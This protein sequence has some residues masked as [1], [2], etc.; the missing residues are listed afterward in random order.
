MTCTV[1]NHYFCWVCGL[2][3]RH[4]VH[5]FENFNL[6]SCKRFPRSKVGLA[7]RVFYFFL[8]F[9][10]L[11]LLLAIIP[12]FLGTALGGYL[13]IAFCDKVIRSRKIKFL[14]KSII[15]IMICIPFVFLMVPLGLGLGAALGGLALGIL[16]FPTFILHIYLHARI[17]W[18]WSKSRV[19]RESRYN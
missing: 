1:C 8:G 3:V 12:P 14:A 10:I 18:F 13:S 2:P 4:W 5:K 7:L 19:R 6:F 17:F 15:I 9:L 16:V 11:P